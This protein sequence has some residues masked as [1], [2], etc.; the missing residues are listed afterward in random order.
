M[1][2]LQALPAALIVRRRPED[3]GL[4]PDRLPAAYD[5]S[6][7]SARPQLEKEFSWTLGESIR[8]TTF[9]F[10]VVA[11]M[12]APAVNAGVGFHLV[13]YYTDVEINATIAV[14]AMGI[15]ALT[16][17]LSNAVWGFLSEKLPERYLV[18][19]SESVYP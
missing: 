1:V 9:W 4:G 16:G 15:Y 3:L 2:F 5:D 18:H 19:R 14:G 7:P 12:V 13:A 11:I 6:T 8:T 17:A 10:L